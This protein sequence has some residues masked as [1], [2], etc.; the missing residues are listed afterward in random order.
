MLEHLLADPLA[1]IAAAAV[2]VA[3]TVYAGTRYRL[4]P[5]HDWV[6]I[7]R[8]VCLPILDPIIERW[9]GGVGAAYEIDESELAARVDAGPEAVERW[10]WE[11][12]SRRNPASAFKNLPD[13]REMVGAW[14]YRGPEVPEKKQLDIML[15]EADGGTDVA[16]HIE[17]S[18][19]LTWLLKDPTVLIR[20]YRGAE[21]DPA[22]GGAMLR[23]WLGESELSWVAK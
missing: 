12:D 20:H 15:F 9:V 14:A 21:Y 4:G 8:A 22:A 2:A 16:A 19:A 11:H 3:V 6:E 1:P 5:A 18:S 23:A 17:F 7:V 13:G 10:L